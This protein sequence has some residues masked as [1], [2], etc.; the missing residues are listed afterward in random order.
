MVAIFERMLQKSYNMLYGKIWNV[1]S[2]EAFG[3]CSS[4]S[5]VYRIEE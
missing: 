3:T 2:A 5:V 1:F 4:N